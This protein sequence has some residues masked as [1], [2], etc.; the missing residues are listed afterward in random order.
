MAKGKLAGLRQTA[1]AP[2][3][4]VVPAVALVATCAGT[5]H[6]VLTR[7]V[8]ASNDN[9][10]YFIVAAT[11]PFMQVTSVTLTD[12]PA[13]ACAEN[14]AE[15]VQTSAVGGSAALLPN[16]RR[17]MVLSNLAVNSGSSFCNGN[18][19]VFNRGAAGGT[20]ILTLPDGRRVSG[21]PSSPDCQAN[22]PTPGTPAC[23]PI[24]NVLTT[25]DPPGP[26]AVP[27]GSE[28]TGINR[29]VGACSINNGLAYVFPSTA[30]TLV[31]STAASGEVGGQTVTLD[32][33][34]TSGFGNNAPG[35]TVP[36]LQAGRDGFLLQGDGCNSQNVPSATCQLIVFI[37]DQ[38]GGALVAGAGAAGFILAADGTTMSTSA[39]GGALPFNTATPTVPTNTP[40]NTPTPSPPPP[41]PVVP[42]PTSPAAL[43]MISGLG[44][45][46]A[47]RL[48]RAARV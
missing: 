12:T 28:L 15:P 23:L 34:R 43:V 13:S 17:T 26:N 38:R 14:S 31:V 3:R 37:A 1:V 10:G 27:Q 39:F 18:G 16:P 11:D 33:T 21:N 30:N 47:W 24:F 25:A 2:S 22:V 41:I 40:T 7:D 32:D 19:F 8:C 9:T 6:A 20:G 44:L 45:A 4:L 48:R 36:P 46:L 5:S 42:T 29:T 35:N